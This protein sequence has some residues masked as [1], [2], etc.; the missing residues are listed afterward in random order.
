MYTAE[1]PV[2][3][4]SRKS[5]PFGNCRKLKMQIIRLV[6]KLDRMLGPLSVAILAR[7]PPLL[8]QGALPHEPR[9]ILL[10]RPGGIGDAVLLVPAICALK[11]AIPGASIEVL[12]ER[13]N[14]A[15]F[16]HCSEVERIFCYDRPR[17]LLDVLRRR[18][19]VV[20]DT[21]QWH[22]L[23]AVVCRLVRSEMKIGFAT[24][25]RARMFTHPVSYELD[26]Y[27]AMSFL[28]LL[29]P[30]GITASDSSPPDV[31]TLPTAARQQAAD[32]LSPLGQQPF[33]ALFA[34]ASIP[35]KRWVAEN[36]REVIDWCLADGMAV[37]MVGGD[38]DAE[39]NN[40]IASG[41]PV[42]NL[43]GHTSLAG[44]AAVLEL[45]ACVVSGDSGVLHLAAGLNRPTVALFGPS[46]VRK[47]A[48]R[49]PGHIVL[50]TSPA[51]SPCSK[52]GYTPPCSNQVRCLAELTP[53]HVC[54]AIAELRS[55]VKE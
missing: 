39:T 23:S 49:G 35:E 52:F 9:A 38:G 31:L 19:D 30:L 22:R 54:Q 3:W 14:Y 12:A 7:M 17:E 47:W 44:T 43:A 45:A 51:C 53:Q 42:L 5:E 1:L 13:R 26:R 32:L 48:P 27:E 36:F 15:I 28:D 8:Y 21:E 18:Y 41:R 37:V 40:E 16:E 24:N 50:T 29:K 34:G 6:K 4:I 11:N 25:E 20:I 55:E 2:A 46:N 10:I 33:L